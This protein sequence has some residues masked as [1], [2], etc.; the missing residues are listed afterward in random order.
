MSGRLRRF[1]RHLLNELAI[2]G[3]A[4]LCVAPLAALE[5]IDE[6][7][8]F[9][10]VLAA[11]LLATALRRTGEE[12]RPKRARSARS[13][14]SAS[15]AGA[16]EE[17]SAA[18][19]LT[20]AEAR[21]TRARLRLRRAGETDSDLYKT[22]AG[23]SAEYRAT[24]RAVLEGEP[25]A[26]AQAGRLRR[27]G[28]SLGE[29]AHAAAAAPGSERAAQAGEALREALERLRG[30]RLALADMAGEAAFEAHLEALRGRLPAR[31][32]TPDPEPAPAPTAAAPEPPKPSEPFAAPPAPE[33]GP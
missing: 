19:G 29:L 26:E 13:E 31:A 24:R 6:D 4:A 22:L 9:A 28:E 10:F 32:A 18:R 16:E 23:L 33:R 27:I 20:A 11:Y 14:A 30:Q 17:S 12:G 21:L 15:A 8:I 5:L 25:G 7:W 1:R 3:L 2:A